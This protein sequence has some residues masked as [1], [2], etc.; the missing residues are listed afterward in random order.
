MPPYWDEIKASKTVK[1][2]MFS[3]LKVFLSCSH[4]GTKLP[5]PV[6]MDFESNRCSFC[7]FVENG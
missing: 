4:S 6:G 3:S 5:N 7:M 1:Q 2:N